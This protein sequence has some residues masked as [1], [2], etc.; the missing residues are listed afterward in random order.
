LP[1]ALRL[2]PFL[3]V[4]SG[5]P[6]NITIGSDT[7][8]DSRFNDRPAFATDLSRPSVVK[9]RFGAFDLAPLPGQKIVPPE[10]GT[11]SPLFTLNMRVSKTFGFGEVRE[12][13][14]KGPSGGAP[15]GLLDQ[16]ALG[17]AVPQPY[18]LTLSVSVRNIFNY[19]NLGVP[20]GDL[21]SPLFGVPT[22]IS[23][24]PY[25]SSVA[26]RRVDLRAQFAF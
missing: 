21:S 22:G 16:V 14:S 26:N 23:G 13:G 15:G 7:N 11:A 24:P 6:F 25:S 8:G 20:V 9:T 19:I 10:F 2:T 4:E 17:D 3:A 18:R 5:H 12:G 1:H